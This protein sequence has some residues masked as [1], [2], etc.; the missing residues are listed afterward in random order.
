M[1]SCSDT[2][3]RRM[4]MTAH[5][6]SESWCHGSCMAPRHNQTGRSSSRG[7]SRQ[8]TQ[9]PTNTP[10]GTPPSARPPQPRRRLPPR[11]IATWTV[12]A[13]G[14]PVAWASRSRWASQ[15]QPLRGD[16]LNEVPRPFRGLTLEER[17]PADPLSPLSEEERRALC[18]M[19]AVPEIHR[20]AHR[21]GRL[22]QSRLDAARAARRERAAANDI[23]AAVALLQRQ[24]PDLLNVPAAP[25]PRLPGDCVIDMPD[26]V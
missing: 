1:A 10:P 14:Y 20:S 3:P 2:Y 13:D 17:H 11:N 9:R 16:D 25:P 4:T 18:P 23:A 19:C 8:R 5:P 7:C 12:V 21:R 26:D 6:H 24:R 15:H 22:H